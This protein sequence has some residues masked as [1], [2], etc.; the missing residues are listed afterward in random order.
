M[1]FSPVPISTALAPAGGNRVRT[2]AG[3]RLD[4]QKTS[5]LIRR[6]RYYAS[7]VVSPP[8]HPAYAPGTM[9][10]SYSVNAKDLFIRQTDG[11]LV[12][13]GEWE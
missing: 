2:Q 6:S 13:D 4:V 10:F 8:P 12:I 5:V 1:L 7:R 3:L 11:T 9:A